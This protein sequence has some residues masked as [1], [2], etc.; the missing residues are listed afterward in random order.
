MEIN[1]N[2]LLKK[3]YLE[4]YDCSNDYEK[5]Y[6]I[7]FKNRTKIGYLDNNTICLLVEIQET[8]ID[9]MGIKNNYTKLGRMIRKLQNTNHIQIISEVYIL[10]DTKKQKK[11]WFIAKCKELNLIYL[12]PI[13][14]QVEKCE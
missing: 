7:F 14:P 1:K 10:P 11:D 8:K 5:L 3:R 2:K 4:V 13:K 9:T 6:N 12:P